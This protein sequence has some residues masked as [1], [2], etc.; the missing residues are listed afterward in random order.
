MID[1][2]TYFWIFLKAGALSTGG[3]GN[4]PSLS[5]DLAGRGWANDS[6]FGAAL[7]VGQITPGPTGLWVAS[8]GYLTFGVPGAAMAVLA[9]SIPPMI[10]LPV[11]K[12]YDRYGDLAVARDFMRGL[13]IAVVSVFP[14][15]M[16]RLV[17]SHDGY[18]PRS[19]LVVAA[20][21]F[22]AMTR[23]VPPVVV[24]A[25]SAASGVLLLR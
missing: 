17:V 11:G 20:G 19:L 13:S 23:R 14:I 10:A 6:Q 2:F 1:P 16:L 3:L 21:F 5:Q 12:L 15:V 25:I 8:L 4:L 22:L 24:L 18:D 7:A 9:S